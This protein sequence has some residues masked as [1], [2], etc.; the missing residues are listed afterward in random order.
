[1]SGNVKDSKGLNFNIL[2]SLIDQLEGSTKFKDVDMR[3]FSK[4]LNEKEGYEGNFKIDM[5]LQPSSELDVRDKVID[6]S[7]GAKLFAS[8][9]TLK[10]VMEKIAKDEKKEEIKD[11]TKDEKTSSEDNKPS[12]Q[13]K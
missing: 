3:N 4:T 5:S 9:E 13:K 7:N 11:E 6:L 1:V 2:A 12:N 10:K 8:D